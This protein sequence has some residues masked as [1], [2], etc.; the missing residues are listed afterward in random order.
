MLAVKIKPLTVE[1]RETTLVFIC[2]PYLV[3]SS[4]DF[5]CKT[6]RTIKHNF[7]D[8]IQW[9][10]RY[11]MRYETNG[12]YV[13]NICANLQGV[14]QVNI[15]KDTVVETEAPRTHIYIHQLYNIQ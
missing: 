4:L 5:I 9:R 12:L 1:M 3:M 6:L 10:P 11:T 2:V 8:H 7:Y 15:R 14:V 13:G